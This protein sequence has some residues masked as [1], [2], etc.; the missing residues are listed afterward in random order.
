[1]KAKPSGS[2]TTEPN[3]RSKPVVTQIALFLE[4]KPGRIEAITGILTQADINL[5]GI[6]VSSQGDYG[7]M[8]ILPDN[9]EKAF[10]V[11]KNQHLNLSKLSVLVA[12]ISDK[13]GSLH[14]MLEL[15]SQHGINIEECY[16]IGLT[17]NQKALIV[18]EVD[19]YK[20][21]ET[22]LIQNGVKLFTDK[23]VHTL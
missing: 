8:K 12:Q 13:P 7:V 4:N 20:Q 17:Q 10:T 21:A 3:K 2:L 22:V 18:L 1:M 11:L 6:T 14:R 19:D 16:G 15:L 23:E 9:P 5:R